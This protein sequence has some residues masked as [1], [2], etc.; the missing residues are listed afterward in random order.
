MAACNRSQIIFITLRHCVNINIQ[1]NEGCLHVKNT[2]VSRA[3]LAGT[4][5]PSIAVG[6]KCSNNNHSS[7]LCRTAAAVFGEAAMASLWM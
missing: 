1:R 4:V 6:L 7:K 5:H 2:H 3:N